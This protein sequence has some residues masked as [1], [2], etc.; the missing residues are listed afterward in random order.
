MKKI[1]T[2][3]TRGQVGDGETKITLFD[4]KFNTGYRITKIVIAASNTAED[5]VD[6]TSVKLATVSGLSEDT[7]DWSDNTEIAWAMFGYFANAAATAFGGP[8]EFS[9]IDPDNMI[10]EDLFLYVQSRNEDPINYLIEMEK[11]DISDWQGALAMVRNSS[12]N[13][14]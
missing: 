7:W 10:I 9:Q 2:Y 14:E 12:Q 5:E 3:T 1:G 4:G 13:V 11:Y 8:N 6:F